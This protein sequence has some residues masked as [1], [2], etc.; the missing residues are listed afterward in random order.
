MLA[1]CGH[2]RYNKPAVEWFNL[3]SSTFI[4]TNIPYV[5]PSFSQNDGYAML[6]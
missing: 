5:K 6:V 3:V 1:L 4:V 2:F